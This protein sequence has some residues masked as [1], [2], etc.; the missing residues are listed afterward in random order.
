MPASQVFNV[1]MHVFGVCSDQN[2]P[3]SSAQ[4]LST[5]ELQII[6]TA[7][8][9]HP[10]LSVGLTVCVMLTLGV[11]AGFRAGKLCALHMQFYI[12][13]HGHD[14]S[15]EVVVSLQTTLEIWGGFGNSQSWSMLS[16]NQCSP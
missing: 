11:A 14:M 8:M 6:L 9:R 2:D 15:D 13:V 3:S 16:H 4:T 7:A 1:L 10:N 12:T 5:D